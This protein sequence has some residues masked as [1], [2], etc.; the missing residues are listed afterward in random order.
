MWTISVQN[1]GKIF[2]KTD[3]ALPVP[4]NDSPHW[5]AS[6]MAQSGKNP[7]TFCYKG[8]AVK[9]LNY[10]DSSWGVKDPS[11][12]AWPWT[13]QRDWESLWDSCSSCNI[14]NVLKTKKTH[15]KNQPA[16]CK[17]RS[18]STS[19]WNLFLWFLLVKE[20]KL[21]LKLGRECTGLSPM[22]IYF[23]CLWNLVESKETEDTSGSLVVWFPSSV[24]TDDRNAQHCYFYMMEESFKR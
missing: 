11:S 12:R 13:G 10:P 2:R 24:F 17:R 6:I 3:W 4:F 15:P 9:W 16:V 1:A 14:L 5:S 20:I 18:Y 21:S 23:L 8:M 19:F 7:R 22:Q